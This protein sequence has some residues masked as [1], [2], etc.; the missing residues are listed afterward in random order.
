MCGL[1]YAPH[2]RG[3]VAHLPRRM[4]RARAIG[5]AAIPRNAD[6]PNVDIFRLVQ[7][8]MGQPHEGGDSAKAR[9]HKTGSR[10]IEFFQGTAL[11]FSF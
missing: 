3:L 10:L 4:A 6:E 1:M 7:W 8:H 2:H 9:H 5:G 11:S